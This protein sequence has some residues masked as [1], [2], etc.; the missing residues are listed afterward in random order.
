RVPIFEY[1]FSADGKKFFYRYTNC[2]D[3]FNLKL[4]IPSPLKPFA[5]NPT[6]DKW[7]SIPITAT[8]INQSMVLELERNYYIKLVEKKEGVVKTN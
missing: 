4:N 1:Y 5:L 7:Q 6:V 2:V 3:G 8:D